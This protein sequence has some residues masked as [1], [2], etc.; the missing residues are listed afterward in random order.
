MFDAIAQG[1]PLFVVSDAT[2]GTAEQMVHAALVQFEG[3]AP[4]I[5]VWPRV[6]TI[7]DLDVI[8]RDAQR[9]GALVVHTLVKPA[10][11]EHLHD[12]ADALGIA[13]IDVIG[14]I[15]S[16]LSVFLQRPVRE[17]PGRN[18]ELDEAYFRRIA[19]VEYTVNADDGRGLGRLAA[20]DIVLVG[21][22]RTSKTPVATY[23]AGQGFKVANVPLVRSLPIPAE[24][25]TL[26]PGR[27]FALT[28][29]ADQLVGIRTARMQQLGVRDRGDYADVEHVLDELR[30]A[31]ALFRQRRWPV[32]NVTNQAIE[33]TASQLLRL[34]GRMA[35]DASET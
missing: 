24:L 5:R 16:K 2:G 22:S 7:A 31:T 1:S 25:A 34:R 26:P 3:P 28:I 32:I 6:R 15:L 10:H 18:P 33:E 35:E 27:V 12:R 17:R 21:I 8:L 14:P 9:D 4:V 20:A 29:D 30:W 23:L 11:A 13:C 19:A